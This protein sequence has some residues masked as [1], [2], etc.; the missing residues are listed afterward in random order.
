V[1]LAIAVVVVALSEVI[2]PLL[3]MG[4]T[5]AALGEAAGAGGPILAGMFGLAPGA[6]PEGAAEEEGAASL[7][8]GTGRTLTHFTDEAGARGIAG[9]EPLAIGESATVNQLTFAEGNNAFLA[10]KPGDISV[11]ELGPEASTRQLAQIG[12]FGARQQYAIQFSA[13]DAFNSGV[14]VVPADAERSIFSIPGGCTII[15]ICTVTRVR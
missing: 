4:L 6:A 8:S 2:A 13:E 7:L 1:V 15:G 10:N 14:R 5:T 12:V 9:T 11:T 3:I